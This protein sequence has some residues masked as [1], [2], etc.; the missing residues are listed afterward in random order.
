MGSHHPS[1]CE[2]CDA[3]FEALS[4]GLIG[5]VIEKGIAPSPEGGRPITADLGFGMKAERM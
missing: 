1:E 4:S 5:E 2:Y 3:Q